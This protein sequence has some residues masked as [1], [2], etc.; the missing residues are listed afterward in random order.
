MWFSDFSSTYV[1]LNM[2][3]DVLIKIWNEDVT[4]YWFISY[5]GVSE[6]LL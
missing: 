6:S 1:Y 5:N 3:L 4:Y 2:M